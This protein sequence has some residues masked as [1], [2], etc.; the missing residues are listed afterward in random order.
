MLTTRRA[1]L[2]LAVIGGALPGSARGARIWTA[3]ASEKIRAD[4]PARV[5][6]SASIEAAQNEF[7]AFQVI[8]TGPASGVSAR[9]S[10][11]EGPGTLSGA[12]LYREDFLEV[13]SPSADD[14]ATGLI[15]DALVPD[16][17]DVVGE[18]R[19]AFPFDVPKGQSRGIWV[20][21]HVPPGA[22]PGHYQATVTV[23]TDGGDTNVPV[24]LKVWSFSLPSTASIKTAFSM[25]YGGVVKQHGAAGEA[26]TQLRQRYAQLALD[27]RVSLW[28][29]WDDGTQEGWSH[30]DAAY[31]PFLDGAAP[32]QLPGAKL[33]TLKS[34]ASL[35][36]ASDHADW[37]AH[38]RSRG[39]FERLFQFSGDEPPWF[40]SWSDIQL[41]AQN[42]K[43]ADPEF[44]TF[45]TTELE[46]VEARNLE[47]SIDAISSIIN[48]ME[49]RPGPGSSG[50]AGE[51][52]PKYAGFL[53]SSPLKEL[54]LYQSCW[55]FGCGLVQTTTGWPTYAVDSNAVRSRAM[56]WLSHR[57][58]AKGEFYYEMTQAFYSADPWVDQRAYGGTGDGTL[59]YPGTATRI[60]G[61][62]DI[63]VASIRLK[64]IRESYEDY[65]YLKML[66]DLGGAREAEEIGR[67][68]FPH[69]WETDQSPAALMAAR[70]AIAEEIQGRHSERAGGCGCQGVGAPV[71]LATLLGFLVLRL[72][73]LASRRAQPS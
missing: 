25:S 33:T 66:S 68:L 16:V 61:Q 14:G 46:N 73:R 71:A 27:H 18:K 44:R 26:L 52:Y 56:A 41:R 70:R 50:S 51:K 49:D 65:E 10:P 2:A 42:A 5:Q 69:A 29:L 64:M 9:V 4:E 3:L 34:G 1:A 54:W 17:D 32:T 60:G 57:Y 21:L 58:G 31:G 62:T 28:N 59:F 72:R 40:S 47:S 22:A 8:V 35:T 53:S 6:P 23:H 38:F 39:W 30:F 15:P 48:S 36:S 37:A 55:S 11:F 43:R 13:L 19:N 7:E 20:E 12:K 67:Q 24:A 45:V 63:P